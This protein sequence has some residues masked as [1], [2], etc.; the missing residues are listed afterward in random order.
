VPINETALV[1]GA[2]GGIGEDLARLIAA[3]GRN[4]VLLARSADKLQALAGSLASTHGIAATVVATDLAEPG[5]EEIVARTLAARGVT[6]DILVNNAGFGTSGPFARE[7]PDELQRM[8]QVNVVALTALTRLFLPAMIE[9]KHGRILNVASTA[10]F[11][12]G[13][14]MAGYY[15]TKAYVLSLSEALSEETAGTGVTVTCLC[16]GPTQTGFQDRA[17]IEE[18]RLVTLGSVMDSATVARAGYDA[19]LA[20]RRL[21][22]PGLANKIGVQAVRTSPRA[23]VLKIV[24]FLNSK[25]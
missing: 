18:T 22:I 5:A 21:V 14:F 4:V 17:H 3:G 2:S 11:Q 15:A 6:V 23:M 12:P 16:P 24:R 8:V 9:R 19:M 20:G 1:T 10:G 25:H 7:D 13:P